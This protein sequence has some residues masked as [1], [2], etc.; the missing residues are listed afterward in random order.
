M[1]RRCPAPGSSVGAA[2]AGSCE[3]GRRGTSSRRGPAG[4]VIGAMREMIRASRWPAP[5]R[6]W[7]CRGG[8]DRRRRDWLR[9]SRGRCGSVPARGQPAATRCTAMRTPFSASRDGA[10]RLSVDRSYQRGDPRRCRRRRGRETLRWARWPSRSAGRGVARG[11]GTHRVPP[12]VRRPARPRSAGVAGPRSTRD[13][14]TSAA[15]TSTT[16]F[17]TYW[18]SSVG[19]PAVNSSP[20][21]NTI[22]E[23]M[24]TNA[25]ART[26]RPSRA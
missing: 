10:S 4:G 8:R 18:P 6:A 3:T 13:A 17:S 11:V 12:L 19:P 7:G 2:R 5:R 14:T 21:K 22:G 20:G 23:K 9:G 26:T 15:A 24:P 16:F 1:R 25:I